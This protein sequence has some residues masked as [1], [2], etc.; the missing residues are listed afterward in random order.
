MLYRKESRFDD[1]VEG[2]VADHLRLAGSRRGGLVGDKGDGRVFGDIQKVIAFD[3]LVALRIAGVEAVGVDGSID[4]QARQVGGV[5]F[6]G[7]ADLGEFASNVGDGQV[8]NGEVGAA[9]R[10]VDRIDERAGRGD[11]GSHRILLC[12]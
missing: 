6:Y 1:T 10:G 12:V 2:Q 4:A 8:S 11:L 5:I 3:M 7:A 9:V